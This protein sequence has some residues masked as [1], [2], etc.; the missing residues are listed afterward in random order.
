M[1]SVSARRMQGGRIGSETVS[2]FEKG[3]S[4]GLSQTE[5]GARSIILKIYVRLL[6]RCESHF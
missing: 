1:T 2:D 6:C 3:K 4:I 5:G